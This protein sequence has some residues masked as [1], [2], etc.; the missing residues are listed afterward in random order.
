MS[1]SDC[2]PANEMYLLLSHPLWLWES[3]RI[4][5]VS[6]KDAHNSKWFSHCEWTLR[7]FFSCRFIV[8]ASCFLFG[9]FSLFFS[10]AHPEKTTPNRNELRWNEQKYAKDYDREEK[11]LYAV[12]NPLTITILH[13][14]SLFDVTTLYKNCL[15]LVFL[16]FKV[17]WLGFWVCTCSCHRDSFGMGFLA[18]LLSNVDFERVMTFRF[19]MNGGK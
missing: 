8:I 18:F 6:V 10:R 13:N 7:A 3:P 9:R 12:F 4:R 15:S 11:H 19:G 2:Q 16:F 5:L 17:S 14:L 1:F